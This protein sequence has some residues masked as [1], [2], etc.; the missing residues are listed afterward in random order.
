M[1][2]VYKKSVREWSLP[3]FLCFFFVHSEEFPLDVVVHK[4]T[5]P[6]KG[7]VRSCG[8]GKPAHITYIVHGTFGKNQDWHQS[9]GDFYREYCKHAPKNA[10]IYS[11]VW[12][13]G[14][15]H[16]HR[17][18]AA[19]L[20]AAYIKLTCRPTD[21][22]TLIGHSHGGNVCIMAV[23]ELVRRFPDYS[24]DHL[25]SLGTPISYDDLY[26]PCMNHIK[27]LYHFFSFGDLIQP[28]FGLFHRIFMSHPRIWNSALMLDA[29]IIGHSALRHPAI[30]RFLH[31]CKKHKLENNNALIHLNTENDDVKIQEDGL[32]ELQLHL[33]KNCFKTLL[34]ISLRNHTVE[35]YENKMHE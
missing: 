11:F 33:E 32:R 19:R 1:R 20:L 26:N 4:L 6:E 8:D 29:K 22:I 25:F 15:N 13:G 12:S 18:K 7:F 23:N 24:I 9:H 16:K 31:Y 14:C 17:L 21:F 28:V 3:L 27:Q 2:Y 34:G 35:T 5:H 10:E 30:A